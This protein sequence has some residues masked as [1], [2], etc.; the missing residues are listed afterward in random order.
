MPGCS[1]P[2]HTCQIDHRQER[3]DSGR[4]DEDNL[5]PLC[6]MHHQLKTK[7]LWKLDLDPEGNETWTSYL[8]YTYTKKPAWF[9]LPEPLPA[10]EDNDRLDDIID[11]LPDLDPPY[12]DEIPLPEPP[13]L[14]GEELETMERAVDTLNAFGETFEQWCERHYDQARATGLVA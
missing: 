12:P 11:R 1:R 3:Q 13:P 14:T 5:G 10:E 6:L 4:T 7:K 8:G 2:A 9:P